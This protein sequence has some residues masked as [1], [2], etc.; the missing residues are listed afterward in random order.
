[1]PSDLEPTVKSFAAIDLGSNSFHLA[2]GHLVHGELRWQQRMSEKVQLAAGIDENN[3]L[4]EATTQRALECLA[5]FQKCVS[6][7]PQPQLRIVGTNALRIIKNSQALLE[8]IEVLFKQRVEVISGRE[9]ARL[10]YLGVS[11]TNPSD[12]TKQLVIDIGGGSTEF[13][14]GQKFQPI[15][16]ESLHMGCISFKRLFFPDDTINK[17]CFKK[18]IVAARQ[19]VQLIAAKYRQQ[20]WQVALGAS[21]SVKSVFQALKDL[22]KDTDRVTLKDL[23]FLVNYLIGLGDVSKINLP[24]VKSERYPI[25]APGLAILYGAMQQ[26]NVKEL[27]YSEGALREGLIYDLL[28]RHEP[29]N[30]RRRTL[31]AT[32]QRYSI[33]QDQATR[34]MKTAMHLYK[35]FAESWPEIRSP[36]YKDLL[37]IAAELHEIGICIAHSQF[38]KHGAYLLTY[39]DLAGFSRQ[40]QAILGVMIRLHRRK[41]ASDVIAALP[42]RLQRPTQAL[43][44]ILRLATLLHRGRNLNPAQIAKNV[45]VD[46][47]N[48]SSNIICM[49]FDKNWLENNPLVLMDLEKEAEILKKA[50]LQLLCMEG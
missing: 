42:T 22:N 10:I 9:E 50:G 5:R 49:Q 6:H 25:F 26:L 4:N 46:S 1:M 27:R 43:V 34:V 24:N 12:K 16:T 13:I 45:T 29:E 19:E 30:V 11:H 38:H 35:S 3:E 37:Q 20:G 8:K 47:A 2:I 39:S 48:T 7:I 14:I 23:E 21:G 32:L 18:A 36:Y 15:L 17:A 40:E 44:L 28:G 31:N 41:F 33:D